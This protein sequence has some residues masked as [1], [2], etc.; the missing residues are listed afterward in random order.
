MIK[1]ISRREFLKLMA[2]TAAGLTGGC[3]E[4]KTVTLPNGYVAQGSK[5][6]SSANPGH[7]NIIS[8]ESDLVEKSYLTGTI[9]YI[10]PLKHGDVSMEATQENL[11]A[12]VSGAIL[13]KMNPGNGEELIFS[14]EKGDAINP[15]ALLEIYKK[16]DQISIPTVRKYDFP[17]GLYKILNA[18]DE[19]RT[20]EIRKGG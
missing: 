11:D 5:G 17:Q 12:V 14:V 16:G 2:A 9:T 15:L 7:Y 4:E 6:K 20:H 8:A 19:I 18:V 13:I 3:L 10:G 1:M